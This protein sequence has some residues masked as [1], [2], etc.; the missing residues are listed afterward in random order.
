MASCSRRLGSS[1]VM[2]F[3]RRVK[4]KNEESEKNFSIQNTEFVKNIVAI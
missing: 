2:I 4:E 3:G 1:V